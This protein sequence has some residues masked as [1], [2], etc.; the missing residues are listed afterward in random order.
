MSWFLNEWF[1][2]SLKQFH[3]LSNHHLNIF[4]DIE[5]CTR[6]NAFKLLLWL[7]YSLWLFLS[8]YNLYDSMTSFQKIKHCKHYWLK[9]HFTALYTSIQGNTQK[10]YVQFGLLWYVQDCKQHC[11]QVHPHHRHMLKVTPDQLLSN[12]INMCIVYSQVIKTMM[13]FNNVK[14]HTLLSFKLIY[15]SN[16]S[17]L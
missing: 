3:L 9:L 11:I 10:S 1:G 16:R 4:D 6:Q 14:C 7:F 8:I 5:H 13:K 12:Y 17:K 2:K 15:L